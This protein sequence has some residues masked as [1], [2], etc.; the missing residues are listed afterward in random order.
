MRKTAV[1]VIVMVLALGSF[2]FA[3]EKVKIGVVNLQRVVNESEA[4]KKAT[5]QLEAVIKERQA[6]IDEKQVEFEK[7]QKEM[8]QKATVLSEDAMKKRKEEI[9]K[10]ER[11]LKRLISDSN[12]ELQKL[13]REKQL[14]IQKELDALITKIGKDNG[15]T[16]ILPNEVVLYYDDAMDMTDLVIKDYDETAKAAGEKAPAEKKQ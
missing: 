7:L 10:K 9:Q 5:S 2:A 11:D 14:G 12:A 16:I 15:Y 1:L 4:G 13:Q 8:E 6:K 3:A